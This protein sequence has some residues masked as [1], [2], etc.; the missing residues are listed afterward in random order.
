M[1]RSVEERSARLAAAEERCY[2]LEHEV[3]GLMQRL[4][5]AEAKLQRQAE[6]EAASSS[7]VL[8]QRVADLEGQIRTAHVAQQQAEQA[9]TR[10]DEELV[11]LRAEVA[12]VRRQLADAHSVDSGDLQ[13][14]LKDVTDM[15]YLKQTQLE[16][17][18][19]DKAAQQLAL[20]R[21]LQHARSEAQQVKRR[22]TID[23]SMHG[24]AAADES[25]VPM[26]HLGDAYQ[27]L[28][29]NNRVG[30]AV[31][32]G[33]QLIDST[34]N[35]VVLVLRQYPAGRLVIFAYILGLHLFIYILLHRLQHKAFRAE[36]AA[37][38]LQRDARI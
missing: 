11:A 26:A 25:M 23:R 24:V 1:Q 34:A 9:R 14:R 8:Q 32:A 37:D 4:Q 13:R 30:G 29:N 15:L 3:D 19:A 5:A 21:D 28:A 17:L 7:E 31:K 12:T 35:Q 20:E 16:R 18:A 36:M 2:A 10:A 6:A 38:A 27:R 22:A 33:A